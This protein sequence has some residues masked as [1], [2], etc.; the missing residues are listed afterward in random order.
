MT[1][2]SMRGWVG[3]END[4]DMLWGQQE[5]PLILIMDMLQ[6]A[7]Q[8]GYLLSDAVIIV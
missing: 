8:D 1:N 4:V 5:I 2:N 6:K 7:H 3:Y